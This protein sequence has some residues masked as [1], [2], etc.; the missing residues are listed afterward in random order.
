[1]TRKFFFVCA[2]LAGLVLAYSAA[3]QV[4]YD[5]LLHSSKEPENWLMYSGDYA[6]RR[7]SELKQIN[8][9]TVKNLAPRW[10]YQT[11]GQGKFET[12]PLVV[13]GILYGTGQDDR[14]FALDAR[15]G[16]THLAVPIYLSLGYSSLLWACQSRFRGSGGQSFFRHDGCACRCP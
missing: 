15:T 2:L 1:M 14:T 13:D 10:V 7:H 3:A 12:T 5:R 16:R 11:A 6:G 4:T 9:D 8:V